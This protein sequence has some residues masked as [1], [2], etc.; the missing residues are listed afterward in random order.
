M[1]AIFFPRVHTPV[2]P[3]RRSAGISRKEDREHRGSREAVGDVARFRAQC[4]D[5]PRTF[6]SH[7]AVWDSGCGDDVCRP[8]RGK[9]EGLWEKSID[10]VVKGFE[11]AFGVISH[12]EGCARPPFSL[13]TVSAEPR[14]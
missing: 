1:L 9:G 6:R 7:R 2:N 10:A 13:R 3:G 12:P 5:G 8:G 11:S 14:L 4:H